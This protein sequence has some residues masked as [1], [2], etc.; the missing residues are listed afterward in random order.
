MT[1]NLI[2]CSYMIIFIARTGAFKTYKT[3]TKNG[4]GFL[5]LR[6]LGAVY[7]SAVIDAY[8]ENLEVR[9][10]LEI[11]CILSFHYVYLNSVKM[12]LNATYDNLN[13]TNFLGRKNC[14]SAHKAPSY[15]HEHLKPTTQLRL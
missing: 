9:S 12:Y 10:I 1:S 7:V 11:I 6:P 2:D 14:S 13:T 8:L 4:D 5:E 3:W 15:V